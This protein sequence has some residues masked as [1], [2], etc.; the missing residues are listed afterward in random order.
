MLCQ[1]IELSKVVVGWR[2]I[3]V[4][5]ALLCCWQPPAASA[6]Q[7]ETFVQPYLGIMT[8]FG[9]WHGAISWVYN[10]TNA[11]ALFANSDRVV[12]LL[13]ETMA[14]WEGVC[15]A[16]FSYQGVNAAAVNVS[17]DQ[18]VVVYWGNTN[19]AAAQAGPSLSFS[20]GS[21]RSLGYD[22][23]SDGSVV[24]SPSY[25]WSNNGLLSTVMSEHLLKKVLVHELGHLLGFG[26]SDNP[27][28]IMYANP[29]NTMGH[30]MADDIAAAQDHYGPST[31][32][33]SVAV[34]TPPTTIGSIFTASKLYLNSSG[35]SVAVTS[36]T[37][38]IADSDILNLSLSY[39]GLFAN[40]V[41]VY[42]VDPYGYVI[43]ES[44]VA[45]NCPLSSLCSYFLGV[46][47][48]DILKSVP[49]NYH[50]YVVSGTQLVADLPFTVAT[51][52]VWNHPPAAT[53]TLSATSGA[54]PLTVS[55][56]VTATD[57][58]N[59]TIAVTWHIPG[60]GAVSVGTFSGSDSRS[61]TFSSA[62]QY[63]LFVA[64]NDNGSRYTGV[65]SNSPSSKAGQ[66][67]RVVLRQVVTVSGFKLDIDANG[68]Y[69]ALTDGLLVMRYLSGLRGS[70]L[71]AG[72]VDQT[73]G[74]RT[75]A[76]AIEAYLAD[77]QSVL[78]VDGSGTVTA[79][80]D[81]ALIMRSLFGFS[82]SAL[83]TGL[84]DAAKLS[85]VVAALKVIAP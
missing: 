84:V 13:K 5:V 24:I 55:A 22:P 80:V 69:D 16:Q 67:V 52:P 33:T 11:P 3:L 50:V 51:T 74:T 73:S 2:C 81:G 79:A 20:T 70:S 37:D 4:V 39:A 9:K 83:T 44:A 53:L 54:P 23:F 32:P 34:Y 48:G 14:E 40:T 57:P 28:S 26:H 56:T 49:G 61:M 31:A 35:K 1:Q 29:Y 30:L 45:L 71:I 15:G 43:Q 59:D 77:G 46:G 6:L 64:I 75:S 47:N 36:I 18:T 63:E 76:S 68:K 41:D 72:V 27:V 17:T 38:A 42:V 85:G 7:S 65:G 25:D 60:Q 21:D 78:D 12:A 62:G 8:S 10:P 19:G 58:E 82:G 66:G